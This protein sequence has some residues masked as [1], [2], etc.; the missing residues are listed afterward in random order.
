MGLVLS[1]ELTVR[2]DICSD[3]AIKD[4]I[5]NLCEQAAQATQSLLRQTTLQQLIG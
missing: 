5:E 1:G 3:E 2:K 4:R